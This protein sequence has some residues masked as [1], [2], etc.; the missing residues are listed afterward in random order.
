MEPYIWGDA[1]VT[2]PDWSGTA[3]LDGRMTAPPLADVIGLDSEAW[4]IVGFDIG[5]GEREQGKHDLQ[6]YAVDRNLIRAESDVIKQVAA[7][8]GGEIP[9]TQFLVHDVD[10]YEILAANTHQFSLHMRTRG[11]RDWPI[12]VVALGDVPDQSA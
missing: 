7:D 5:G 3:Q 1:R 10:P 2:Y 9:V 12:R 6:V 4:M 11:T 8:H